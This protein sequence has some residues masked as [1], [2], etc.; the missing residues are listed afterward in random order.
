[1]TLSR[2]KDLIT[3]G[4]AS[5][6]VEEFGAFLDNNNVEGKFDWVIWLYNTTHYKSIGNSE[7]QV[8]VLLK[9]VIPGHALYRML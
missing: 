2:L 1:M 5:C 7:V 6:L 9:I 3:H 4:R 8:V